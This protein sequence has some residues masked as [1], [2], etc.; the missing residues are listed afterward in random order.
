MTLDHEAEL[1]LT[2]LKYTR[3][4]LMA[5]FYDRKVKK[6]KVEVAVQTTNTKIL[7]KLK[8]AASNV[9]SKEEPVKKIETVLQKKL[10]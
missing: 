6:G 8:K 3:D 7:D 5:Q 4:S 9:S 2:K 1:E 10:G